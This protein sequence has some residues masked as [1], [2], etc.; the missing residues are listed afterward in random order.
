VAER[1]IRCGRAGRLG[2]A[3]LRTKDRAVILEAK[4][5]QIA[6]DPGGLSPGVTDPRH[7]AQTH[8]SRSLPV[9]DEGGML[10]PG[11]LN[12]TRAPEPVLTDRQWS[13]IH[14]LATR[15]RQIGPINIHGVQGIPTDRQIANAIDRTLTMHGD[16]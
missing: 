10:P 3:F 9:F 15:G 12:G 6:G 11:V 13:D 5:L 16:W 1:R 2:D 14:A 7:L 8:A 4:R